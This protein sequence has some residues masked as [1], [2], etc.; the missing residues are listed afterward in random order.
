MTT[1]FSTGSATIYQFPARLRGSVGGRCEETNVAEDFTSLRIA[2]TVFGSG[3]YHEA[4]VEE[5]ERAR[6]K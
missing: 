6:K 2:K 3:W 5:A 1:N 4:A